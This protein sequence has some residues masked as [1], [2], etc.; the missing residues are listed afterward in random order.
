MCRH[1]GDSGIVHP[2]DLP[3]CWRRLANEQRRLG[4]EAQ[5]CTLEWCA[6]DLEAALRITADELL[7]I[8]EASGE[9][10]LSEET[11]RRKVRSGVLP[12]ERDT[13]RSRIR[14][15]RRH[16]PHRA[17]KSLERQGGVAY[18]PEEDARSIA[19]LMEGQK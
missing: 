10:G 2:H 13:A 7:T 14:V 18:N 17:R 9:S 3:A 6:S 19:Q 5:A 12:A 11:L 16:L 15:R 1:V 4:A 8:Q